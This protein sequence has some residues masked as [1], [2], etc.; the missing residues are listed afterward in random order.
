MSN[1]ASAFRSKE[2]RAAKAVRTYCRPAFNMYEDDGLSVSMFPIF[3]PR[4]KFY[5][6]LCDTI[7]EEESRCMYLMHTIDMGWNEVLD[8]LPIPFPAYYLLWGTVH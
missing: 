4:R 2:L 3:S 1:A 8:C 7:R 5:Q 6:E